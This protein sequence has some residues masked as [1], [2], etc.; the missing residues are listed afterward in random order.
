MDVGCECMD[1]GVTARSVVQIAPLSG[2]RAVSLWRR[3][4]LPLAV[5]RAAPLLGPAGL[6]EEIARNPTPLS[7]STITLI[8]EVD[9]AIS[10]SL[11]SQS[12]EKQVTA[13]IQVWI[14]GLSPPYA[15]TSVLDLL[16]W[17]DRNETDWPQRERYWA[18]WRWIR[19]LGREGPAG[20]DKVVN[21]R[22]RTLANLAAATGGA[23]SYQL[24]QRIAR[25]LSFSERETAMIGRWQDDADESLDV[26]VA[27]DLARLREIAFRTSAL[28]RLIMSDDE[29]TRLE[30]V[31]EG[32]P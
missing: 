25:G 8:E 19:D 22:I 14:N 30:A 21:G 2:P 1:A 31:V 29:W 6:P 16:S 32:H 18:W 5:Q 15:E 12:K 10:G 4:L 24:V 20:V 17:L 26:V 28:F 9:R 27:L 7:T 13:S 23:K 11:A 3:S